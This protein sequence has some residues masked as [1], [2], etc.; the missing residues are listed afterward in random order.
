MECAFPCFTLND[1]RPCARPTRSRPRPGASVRAA[2]SP[3]GRSSVSGLSLRAAPPAPDAW[4]DSEAQNLP[5]NFN[6]TLEENDIRHQVLMR[7]PSVPGIA[8]CK[9]LRQDPRLEGVPRRLVLL[10]PLCAFREAHRHP[11]VAGQER[12]QGAG[13]GSR[14]RRRRRCRHWR[15][16]F[17]T[18]AGDFLRNFECHAFVDFKQFC[19]FTGFTTVMRVC[20]CFDSSYHCVVVTEDSGAGEKL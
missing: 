11:E 9:C 17:K 7:H 2:W 10:L 14:V 12:G 1:L 5:E 6:L 4:E 20:F 18:S 15:H 13:R 8:L 16:L 19:E 3:R